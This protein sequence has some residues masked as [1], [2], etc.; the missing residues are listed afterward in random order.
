MLVI[1]TKCL[2]DE[3]VHF[4]RV[5]SSRRLSLPIVGAC[6][7]ALLLPWLLLVYIIITM[8]TP[9]KTYPKLILVVFTVLIGTT[10]ILQLTTRKLSRNSQ[11]DVSC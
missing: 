9:S 5:V 8:I 10:S 7:S 3:K 1:K 11:Y 4:V 2:N 6:R